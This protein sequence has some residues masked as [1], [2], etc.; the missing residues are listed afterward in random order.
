MAKHASSVA[1][2]QE[3][4]I[5]VPSE[6]DRSHITCSK[7]KKTGPYANKCPVLFHSSSSNS[8]TAEVF[9]EHSIS[10]LNVPPEVPPAHAVPELVPGSP[11]VL[12]PI[13][14][15]AILKMHWLGIDI[16]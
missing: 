8:S 7:C 16:A 14:E 5:I 1:R 2:N 3:R 15:D 12:S 13:E 4:P 10:S 9:P 6:P 11:I